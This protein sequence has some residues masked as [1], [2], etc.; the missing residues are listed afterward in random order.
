MMAALKVTI[1]KITDKKH[2]STFPSMTFSSSYED[3]LLFVAALQS[4]RVAKK[5]YI[6][7]KNRHALEDVCCS[8][9]MTLNFFGRKRGIEKA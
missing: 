2:F 7:L 6:I 1:K 5:F 4:L 9:R 8:F 3:D